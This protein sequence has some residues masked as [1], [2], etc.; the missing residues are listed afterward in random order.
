MPYDKPNTQHNCMVT[1]LQL[2]FV[3]SEHSAEEH[4]SP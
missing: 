1:N 4:F 3:H 2:Q